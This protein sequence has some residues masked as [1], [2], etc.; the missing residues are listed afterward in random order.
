MPYCRAWLLLQSAQCNLKRRVQILVPDGLQFGG[1]RGQ[2]LKRQ[3][4][5]DQN[6]RTGR[7]HGHLDRHGGHKTLREQ[8]AGW[9]HPITMTLTLLPT[10]YGDQRLCHVARFDHVVRGLMARQ[11]QW[12]G[13]LAKAG[14]VAAVNAGLAALTVGTAGLAGR[15]HGHTRQPRT[16]AGAQGFGPPPG[17]MN[18]TWH[19]LRPCAGWPP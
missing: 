4:L 1:L 3:G 10:A 5:L 16:R 14:E 2:V 19:R 18:T 9:R 11:V 6:Y 12:L 17:A 15:D 13:P 7:I 8:P